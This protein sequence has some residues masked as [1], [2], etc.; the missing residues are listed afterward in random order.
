MKLR[1]PYLTR[2]QCSNTNL[3]SDTVKLFSKN[4]LSEL[5]ITVIDQPKFDNILLMK[6]ASRINSRAIN[7]RGV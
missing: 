3:T 6:K 1:L 7:F 4:A 5:N 2:L